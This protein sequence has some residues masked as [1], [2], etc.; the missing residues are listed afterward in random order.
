M[1]E[2]FFYQLK[3]KPLSAILPDLIVRSLARDVRVTVQAT[4]EDQVAAL[5]A[6]LWGHDD[7]AFLPHGHGDDAPIGQPVWLCAD[8]ANPNGGTFRFYVEGAMPEAVEGLE[9]AIILFESSS[10]ENLLKARNE[11]KKRKAEG[12]QI[13]YYKMDENGKWQNLA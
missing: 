3:A 9:R 11:W 5:S 1:A 8:D 7:V 10:E 6:L 13:R 2:V 4:A 12:H